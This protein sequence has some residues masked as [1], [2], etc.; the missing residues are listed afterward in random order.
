MLIAV[1]MGTISNITQKIL[2]TYH[3]I[4]PYEMGYTSCLLFTVFNLISFKLV[5]KDPFDFPASVRNLVILR[6]VVGCCCNVCFMFGMALLPLSQG[7]VLLM[8]MPLFTAIFGRV[9]LGERLSS[10]DS[11]AMISAF[12]GIVFL[13]NPFGESIQQTESNFYQEAIGSI[14]AILAAMLGG[15]VQVTIRKV[16]SMGKVHFLVLPMSYGLCNMIMNPLFLTIKSFISPESTAT[17]TWGK[18]IAIVGTSFCMFI[19]LVLITL[20]FQ[21]E[22]AGRVSPINYLQVLITCLVD[23]FVFGTK[24]S[25]F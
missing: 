18:S 25:M 14:I 12:I 23:I 21:Y 6:G 11:I 9:F 1:L 4:N 8:T 15:I 10:F 22:K 7:I 2:F 20:A 5:K 16:Q 17:Y 24:I 13:Q 19:Q 3:S